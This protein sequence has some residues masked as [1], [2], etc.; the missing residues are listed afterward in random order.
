V[1]SGG[2]DVFQMSQALDIHVHIYTCM[3]VYIQFYLIT[4][5]YVC[6]YTR[7]GN[8]CYVSKGGEDVYIYVYIYICIFV[9]Q[10]FGSIHIWCRASC[11]VGW[12]RY[13][14]IHVNI[15]ISVCMNMCMNTCMNAY[16]ND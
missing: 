6:I 1:H 3:Y 4:T 15:C 11:V 16:T 14:S 9:T 10:T 5:I 13:E 7:D 8:V 2:V 12:V